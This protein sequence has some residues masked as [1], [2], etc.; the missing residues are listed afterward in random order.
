MKRNDKS[1]APGRGQ[2]GPHVCGCTAACSA[3]CLLMLEAGV[4]VFVLFFFKWTGI[5]KDEI[6]SRLS[7]IAFEWGGGGGV[8][9]SCVICIGSPAPEVESPHNTFH[10]QSTILTKGV[11]LGNDFEAFYT[12]WDCGAGDLFFVADYIGDYQTQQRRIVVRNGQSDP[13]LL[14]DFFF[15]FRFIS[16]LLPVQACL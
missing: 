6:R 1:A 14:I 16:F 11:V 10:N 12:M 5:D 2:R 3:C 9:W 15:F 7:E 13:L 4:Y 8:Q